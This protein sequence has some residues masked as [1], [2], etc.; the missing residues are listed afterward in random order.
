MDVQQK[1]NII[2]NLLFSDDFLYKKKYTRS[3]HHSI[4]LNE[5]NMKEL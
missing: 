5:E 1:N 4:Q 3:A 2:N